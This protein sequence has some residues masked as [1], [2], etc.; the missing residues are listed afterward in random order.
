MQ[1]LGQSPLL[2]APADEEDRHDSQNA[3]D[4]AENDSD[5]SEVV[6]E[7]LGATPGL[8]TLVPFE[9]ILVRVLVVNHD[10]T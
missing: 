9:A 8:A 2:D 4:G 7:D 6:L 1:A 5:P 3:A 10:S